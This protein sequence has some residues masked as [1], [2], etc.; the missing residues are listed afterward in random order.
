MLGKLWAPITIINLRRHWLAKVTGSVTP[1]HRYEQ[2]C[3]NV[4][5]HLHDSFPLISH[6]LSCISSLDVIASTHA[7]MQACMQYLQGPEGFQSALIGGMPAMMLP[8]QRSRRALHRPKR[9]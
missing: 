1:S 8:P 3:V 9:H 7:C 4:W 5:L 2:L 6:Y